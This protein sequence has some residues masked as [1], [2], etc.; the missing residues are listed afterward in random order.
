MQP[1]DAKNPSSD[2]APQTAWSSG[3]RPAGVGIAP[4]LKKKEDCIKYFEAAGR[5]IFL[6]MQV[7]ATAAGTGSRAGARAP[8]LKVGTL[9]MDDLSTF[10]HGLREPSVL[11]G[12]PLLI[13]SPYVF[14]APSPVVRALALLRTVVILEAWTASAAE[15]LRRPFIPAVEPDLQ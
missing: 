15:S 13:R 3:I 4:R 8:C 7:R 6:P 5:G 12:W 14:S 1:Q 11:R 9:F 10:E 2:D